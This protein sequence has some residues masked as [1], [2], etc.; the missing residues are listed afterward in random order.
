[1]QTAK[2]AL[3]LVIL[4]GVLVAC[5][6][7]NTNSTDVQ[8]RVVL[9]YL[10][11]RIAGDEEA[12]KKTMCAAQEGD[13]VR[14]AQSFKSV[15]AKLQDVACTYESAGSKVS[16]TGAIVVTYQGENRDLAPGAYTVVEED[17]EWKVCG[18][19]R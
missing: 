5:G 18:E 6:G 7:A 13:A 12:L 11:A 10:E 8:S 16:C 4:A 3:I 15:E 17:G 9:S 1:M 19:A 2:L 14:I